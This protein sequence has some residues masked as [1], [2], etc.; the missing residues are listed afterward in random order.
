M[1]GFPVFIL[2][3]HLIHNIGVDSRFLSS[4]KIQELTLSMYAS[5][6]WTYIHALSWGLCTS[7]Q[8]GMKAPKLIQALVTRTFPTFTVVHVLPG[9]CRRRAHTRVQPI[10]GHVFQERKIQSVT[11]IYFKASK[12]KC[13]FWT[14]EDSWS[15]LILECPHKGHH[16]FLEGSVF[17]REAVRV[18]SIGTLWDRHKGEQQQDSDKGASAR[19]QPQV[20]CSWW[21]ME[22]GLSRESQG[23]WPSIE[24]RAHLSMHSVISRWH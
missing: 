11:I 14:L 8:L 5:L 6:L 7:P 15:I 20:R 17:P 1:T 16:C 12:S 23:Q 2:T 19:V 13:P 24:P 22:L 3:G 18:M 10:W 4:L 9:L 21:V